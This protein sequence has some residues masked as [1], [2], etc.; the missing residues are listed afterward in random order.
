MADA[1]R[2]SL[3]V[4]ALLGPSFGHDALQQIVTRRPDGD[5]LL[6]GHEP[7]MSLAIWDLTGARVKM[8]PGSMACVELDDPNEL[9]GRL[10]FLIPP[11]LSAG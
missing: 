5:L 9:R 11:D 8:L 2:L 10:R 4:E 6:V 3:E 7:G 1:A